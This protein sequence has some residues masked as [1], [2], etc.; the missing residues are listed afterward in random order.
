VDNPDLATDF[1]MYTAIVQVSAG[2]AP[3][4]TLAFPD[5]SAT[6]W[7]TSAVV[8]GTV[9]A[10][11]P[12]STVADLTCTGAVVSNMAGIGTPSASATLT[13]ATQGRNAISCN[14]TDSAGGTGD[15]P[16]LAVLIDSIAPSLSPTLSSSATL[17]LLNASVFA[18]PNASDSG[19]GVTSAT[20]EPIDTSAAGAHTS[21]C[22][23]ID[24]AGNAAT[25]TLDYVVGFT[26][27]NVAL[28]PGSPLRAGAT[29]YATFQLVDANGQE[30]ADAMAKGLG[31]S[32][33]A[34]LGSGT[35]DCADY[36]QSKD[37]FEAKVKTSSK[38]A[39]GTYP[40]G[41]S[42]VQGEIVLATNAVPVV[43][44]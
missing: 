6:G 8:T 3:V 41:L 7:Y 2:S 29:L 10:N 32:V 40:L 42:V 1:D 16:I 33:T 39:P 23:A 44:K 37:R 26:I 12:A 17:L 18:V 28:S 30:I 5:H 34:S 24:H 31:C 20:C 27:A 22:T 36:N 35:P 25:A 13:V 14:A 21:S 19:S 4:V 43:L 15:S 38:L 9:T 11:S